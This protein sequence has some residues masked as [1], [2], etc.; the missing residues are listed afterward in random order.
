MKNIV[1]FHRK[2]SG[3]K[4]C[5]VRKRNV[6]KNTK[7]KEG[8]R[9]EARKHIARKQENVVLLLHRPS[10]SLWSEAGEGLWHY[11]RVTAWIFQRKV[12]LQPEF[13]NKILR[14]SIYGIWE[15]GSSVW[16]FLVLTIRTNQSNIQTES[17]LFQSSCW[18]EC[19]FFFK[20]AIQHRNSMDRDG[21]DLEC[22]I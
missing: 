13:I 14:I 1:E 17:Q 21:F 5:I 4:E 10:H 9:M 22:F 12:L 7:K 6:K 19:H 20:H 8:K 3:K 16:P 18:I 15:D 11:R 2:S